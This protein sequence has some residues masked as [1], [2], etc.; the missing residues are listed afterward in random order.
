MPHRSAASAPSHSTPSSRRAHWELVLILGTLTAFSP[1]SVDMYLPAF[2]TIAAEL[3][4]PAEAVQQT[5]ALFFLG[6]AGG[7]LIYGPLSD[8]FGRI[9]PL[10]AGLTLYVIAAIGC[11]TAQ[12]VE[13]LTGW[14]L[15]QGLGGCAGIVMAR[16][17]VRDRFEPTEGA[18]M[19]SQLTLV[20]G[21]AP[22]LAPFVGSQLL[23][24]TGWRAIF[25]VLTAFGVVCIA[26]AAWRLEESWRS[27]PSSIHPV[28]IV[29]T[30]WAVLCDKSFLI[31]ALT[32]AISQSAMFTYIIGSPNVFIKQFGI[33]PEHFGFFFGANAMGLI[34]ATQINRKLLHTHQ[35]YSILH[36]STLASL[37]VGILVAVVAWT[38][39]G[40]MWGVAA[41]LFLL[42]TALG[43]VGANG[44]ACALANQ[45][46]R[47]GSASALI[48]TLQFFISA[49]AGMISA[50]LALW[51]KFGGSLLS[52]AT[53]ISFC[54]I[55]S[56][57]LH[58]GA[59]PSKTQVF[60]RW[61]GKITLF[62]N[63]FGS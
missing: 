20:M 44:T 40:G 35:P 60:R 21:I 42:L 16:A 62:D 28:K 43:F 63:E 7:Q 50:Q 59:V 48:G 15:L 17:I 13:T 29:R 4:V 3:H 32:V 27:T 41:T 14:R 37:I 39:W 11:A 55:V 1:L 49:I 46:H 8:R 58:W 34:G 10:L 52:M 19:L 51:D 61:R 22:I 25:W 33:S 53:V 5:L 6:M 36:V 24:F 56:A 9:K 2:P 31:P 45:G 23:L 12:S 57:L 54:T 18:K 38:G 30:F 47:A 26:M